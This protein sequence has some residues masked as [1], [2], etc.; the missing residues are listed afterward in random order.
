MRFLLSAGRVPFSAT[1]QVRGDTTMRPRTP[2]KNVAVRTHEKEGL[3]GAISSGLDQ[4]LW[5]KELRVMPAPTESKRILFDSVSF[6]RFLL[7]G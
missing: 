5:R 1:E 6:S 2:R 3:L 4:S 7:T